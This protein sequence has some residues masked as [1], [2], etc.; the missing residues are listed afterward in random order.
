M[1]LVIFLSFVQHSLSKTWCFPKQMIQ[2]WFN[3][4]LPSIKESCEEWFQ[5][6]P[7][8]VLGT[9]L[10]KNTAGGTQQQNQTD[11]RNE[12]FVIYIWYNC[13]YKYTIYYSLIQTNKECKLIQTK[14]RYHTT[15]GSVT[16]S[17]GWTEQRL[18]LQQTAFQMDDWDPQ[19]HHPK[20][21]TC[22]R[23]T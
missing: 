8:P 10:K 7:N 17:K 22:R 18:K 23:E 2:Y 12:T 4:Q 1:L 20:S 21:T 15:R 6:R 9:H 19:S 13:R 5:S 14:M 16:N 3:R 11:F